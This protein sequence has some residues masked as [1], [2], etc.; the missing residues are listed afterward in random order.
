MNSRTIP[1]SDMAGVCYSDTHCNSKKPWVAKCY[2]QGRPKH[3]GT[4]ASEEE[5]IECRGYYNEHGYEAT[6][7][8]LKNKRLIESLNN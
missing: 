4:F 2:F 8:W 1:Q 6:R 3:L 7:Q 5:A